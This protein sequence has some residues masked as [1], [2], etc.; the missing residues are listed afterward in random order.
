VSQDSAVGF[1]YSLRT[2]R[3]GDRLPVRARFFRNRPYRPW[4][5]PSLLWLL[6]LPPGGKVAGAW[7]WPPTPSSAEVKDTVELY[8]YASS[9]HSWP[10][11][12]RTLHVLYL[13]V[14]LQDR[15]KNPPVSLRSDNNNGY[16]YEDL[17]MRLIQKVSTV[18][19]KKKSSK[20]LYKILLLTDSTIIKIF[21]HIFAAIFETLIVAGHKFFCTFLIECGRLRCDMIWYTCV[22]LTAIE[23]TPGGRSTSHILLTNNTHIERKENNTGNEDWLLQAVPR[24]CELYPGICLTAEEK[25]RKTLS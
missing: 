23:L 9:G 24:L 5:P 6:G 14:F 4:N 17:L 19:L 11:I 1:S 12:G 13:L 15:L 21:F 16:L 3:S 22:C 7:R 8:L 18:S 20:V 10:I 2:G 25:A